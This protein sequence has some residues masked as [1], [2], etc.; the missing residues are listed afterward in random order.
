ME[1]VLNFDGN[2]SDPYVLNVFEITISNMH[3]FSFKISSLSSSATENKCV[4]N[5]FRRPD[6]S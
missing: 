6:V 5:H 2:A 4:G 1:N 3:I